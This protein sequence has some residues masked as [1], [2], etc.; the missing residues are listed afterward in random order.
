MSALV[1]AVAGRPVVPGQ[2][3]R[4][5]GNDVALALSGVMPQ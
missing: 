1:S 4:D 2:L 5:I 3:L